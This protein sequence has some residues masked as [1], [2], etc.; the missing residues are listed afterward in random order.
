M[1]RAHRYAAA[2][3]LALLLPAS[4]HAAGPAVERLHEFFS[5]LRSLEARFEQTIVQDGRVI[6]RTRGRLHILRPGKFRWAYESPFEQLI[7][8]DGETLWV[9]EPDLEQ[10]TRSALDDSVGNTPAILLSTEEPLDNL[11]LIVDAGPKDGLSWAMLEPR[12]EQ[13]AFSR[14]FLGFDARALAAMEIVDALEQ[15]V[16]IRFS[17]ARRNVTLD[18]ALFEFV[19]PEG[20]DVIGEE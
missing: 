4:A 3:L 11:F 1:A 19:A 20:V 8:T 5:D 18:P 13:A 14:I 17:E 10:V 6:Q 15:T 9:Y 7:I 12:G 2:L 16:Q